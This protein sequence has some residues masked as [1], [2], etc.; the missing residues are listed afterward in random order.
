MIIRDGFHNL[1]LGRLAEEAGYSKGTLYNH[2]TCREDLLIELSTESARRQLDSFRSIADLPWSCVWALYGL[3]FA[4]IRHA[5]VSPILFECSIT[6]RTNAVCAVASNDRLRRRDLV[7]SQIAQVVGA[8]VERTLAEDAYT[9]TRVPVPVAV[10]TLRSSLFG[11]AATHLLYEGFLWVREQECEVQ[12][13]VLASL[14]GGLGWPRLDTGDL[15][16]IHAMIV[17]RVTA[18]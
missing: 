15:A 3:G 8:V 16:T 4:Y 14:V 11:Y 10:D 5:E 13:N 9:N 6:A 18:T 1:T 2:F 12:L 17:E 7:E